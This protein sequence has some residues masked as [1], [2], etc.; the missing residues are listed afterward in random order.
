[1]TKTIKKRS[2]TAYNFLTKDKQLREE[3]KRTN[4]EWKQ[5]EMLAEY[6]RLWETW[7]DEEK[8]KYLD[9]AAEAK[10]NFVPTT[11]DTTTDNTTSQPVTEETQRKKKARTPFFCYLHDP[12]IRTAAKEKQ[13]DLKITELTKVISKE[14]KEL[15][16]EEKETWA[17][18]AADEKKNLEENPIW[19][20]KKTKKAR[21]S[22]APLPVAPVQPTLDNQRLLSAEQTI[23]DL[24]NQVKELT[25]LMEE[26]KSAQ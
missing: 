18:M 3:L 6:S 14:W 20:T 26:L 10:A 2:P 1:M 9:Q 16:E 12:D 21:G 13:P 17:T 19:V 8:K 4:P 11:T 24:L 15:T 23:Q 7:G 22:V 5:P 25:R